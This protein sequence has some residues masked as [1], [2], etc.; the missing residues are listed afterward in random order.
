MTRN[1]GAGTA[2]RPLAAIVFAAMLVVSAGAAG[3]AFAATSTE[4]SVLAT[5]QTVDVGQ[6]AT[7]EVVVENT[8]G[9]VGAAEGEVTLT[10]SSVAQITDVSYA[11]SPAST[12][13]DV[14]S[15]GGSATF[16]AFYGSNSL[17]GD[18]PS[19][20]VL[21]VTV[22]GTAAGQTGVDLAE[23]LVFDDAGSG[24]DV[25]ATNG[26]TLTV[27]GSDD[28]TSATVTANDGEGI[29][30]STYGGGSF[31]ITNDGETDVESVTID[32][33]ESVVPDVVFDPDGTAGDAVAKGFSPD[34]GAS[35]TGLVDGTFSAPHNG[36]DGEDGYDVLTIAFDDFQPGETLTFSV[37]IDPTSIK[38]V[39]SSGGA[40]SVSG[41]ELAGSTVTV[42]SADGSV[43]NDLFT[44]GSAGGAQATANGD[45]A[46]APTLG[47]QGV[48]LG[49]TDFPAHAAAT[50]GDQSQ[51]LTVD[52]PAGESVTLLHVVGTPAPAAG[53]DVDDYEAN[54]AASVSTQTVAL[55]SDGS[56]TVAVSLSEGDYD[57]FLAAVAGENSGRTSQTVILEYDSDAPSGPSD[58]EVVFA[59]NA[60][61]NQYTATD[62]TEY[63][64]DT[65]FGGGS[66]YSVSGAPDVANTDDDALYH[67][68]RYGDPFSYD[69]PVEN[70]V[71]EVT[72]QFAEIYQG[73]SP[74][75][76]DT[77]QIGDR[78]FSA[79][80]E[81]GAVELVDYD[82][83]ADVGPLSA[84]E[85]TYTVEVTDGELNVE[86]SASADNAKVS[87][88][89]VRSVEDGSGGGPVAPNASVA[90]TPDS[91]VDATTYTGGSFQVTNTGESA[92][93]TLTL[94]LAPTMLPDMVFD[95]YNTAGD[96]V[97]KE[98]SLDG[99]AVTV[100]NVEYADFHNGVDD[101][102]GYDS[103]VVTLDG[104]DPGETMTFSVDNDPT[105]ISSTP[106]GS[107]AAGP[108]SGLE[109]SGATV[110]VA[111]EA[112]A[113][114]AD[115]VGDGSAGG[116]EASL[117]GDVAPAP[118]IGV[119]GVS[120]DD[121]ILSARHAGAT[122]NEQAQTVT[123]S[124]PANAPVTL[125]RVEGVLDLSDVPTPYDVEDYEANK[126]VVVEY[127]S[128]TTD[129]T[130]Q[131]TVAV[132]L[133]N[134]SADGG[135]N[136][137]VAAVEDGDGDPGFAS[138]YVVLRYDPS[139]TGDDGPG[140]VGEFTSPPT[141]PDGDGVYEDVNGDGSFTVSD[142]QAFFQNFEDGVVQ[143]NEDAFDVN[144]DGSVTIS[145]VQA[146]FV[147][148][149]G[150]NS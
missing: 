101:T 97:G 15:D 9:D 78:V 125:V 132:D 102:A 7:F 43:T 58:G 86:F 104:F 65:N 13:V 105:S 134:S 99:G 143:A 107:Q 21:T 135:L 48:T 144:G 69:V 103:L 138:N 4:V 70:G 111:N 123:V 57:Y 52:G 108:V 76:G 41:L 36:V 11:G 46:A 50:V 37:D 129:A 5:S 35:A 28:A 54:M 79:N 95:P 64:A 100:T 66:T 34:G 73:V 142:V 116:A 16:A 110:T 25:T 75:D 147:A 77:D 87:A 22:E 8:D 67:T 61:G 149:Q 88:I 44:D 85:R 32:L 20:T 82:I 137:F 121:S 89:V 30:A 114:T 93:E 94:D 120:L 119:D 127:Y 3:V 6:T 139:S 10:D 83:Y 42:T 112:G 62:G 18:G 92:I 38:D 146:L 126:A 124:G 14:A 19:V 23:F 49:G 33:S 136:Y 60:G 72:L 117:D 115:L 40:G 128:T 24:Y 1:R 68:E 55:G 113:T 130:G 131:A 148:L 90:V 47:V 29:A 145:D 91:G 45:V 84:T 63:A 122:V 81:G 39:D 74:N 109:L 31:A 17:A 27:E 53:Y 98:F 106:L 133:T 140:P 141:D 56:A 59:V 80:V 96:N 2:L 150:G 12:N 71:Y 118:T 26:A 51:T